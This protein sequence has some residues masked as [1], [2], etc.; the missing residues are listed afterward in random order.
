MTSTDEMVALIARAADR[1]GIAQETLAALLALED[2][3]P[4]FTVPGERTKFGRRVAQIVDA[5]ANEALK[6]KE[7][8]R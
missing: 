6:A 5:A 4:D 7:N 1:N 2:E 8:K 3:F